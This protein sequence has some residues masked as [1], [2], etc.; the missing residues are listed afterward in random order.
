MNA[1][2]QHTLTLLQSLS[3]SI[4]IALNMIQQQPEM[5]KDA[6]SDFEFAAG[7][8]QLLL[9]QPAAMRLTDNF[10]TLDRRCA[11]RSSRIRKL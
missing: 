7:L 8:G 9:G 5:P 10:S 1:T 3:G 6:L 4:A 11:D 2:A